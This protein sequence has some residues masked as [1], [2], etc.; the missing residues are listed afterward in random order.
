[1]KT[2]R[3]DPL[4]VHRV[5]DALIKE[6]NNLES[7]AVMVDKSYSTIYDWYR[8]QRNPGKGDYELMKHMADKAI[9]EED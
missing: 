8:G 1:M 4:E 9:K 6:G 7:I 3:I 2:F 5:M